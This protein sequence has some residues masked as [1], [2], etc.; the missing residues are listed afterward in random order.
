MKQ[1]Y[2]LILSFVLC[3]PAFAQ[4]TQSATLQHGD[5]YKIFYSSDAFKEAIQNASHGDIITLS[6]GMFNAVNITKAITLRGAGTESLDSLMNKNLVSVLIGN[7]TI[8]IPDSIS[9]YSFYMEGITH[10]QSTV[11]INTLKNATFAKCQF[12]AIDYDY[13]TRSSKWQNLSFIHTYIKSGLS[14]PDYSTASFYN[15]VITSFKPSR[16][17]NAQYSLYH[18]LIANNLGLLTISRSYLEN[19]ILHNTGPSISA[20]SADTNVSFNSIYSGLHSDQAF[21]GINS[22]RGNISYPTSATP[23]INDTFYRL[24]DLAKTYKANDDTEI[25]IYGG[26]HPFSITTTYPQIK[27]LIVAPESDSEGKLKIQIEISSN[28]IQ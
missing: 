15:S 27:K 8:T 18:C 24:T 25:G 6:P 10:P 2:A 28:S 9:E 16:S 1:F 21:P 4:G 11:Q 3:L 12:Y 20:L 7:Y 14:C 19:C 22:T 26:S 23:F 5:E 17:S 13:A